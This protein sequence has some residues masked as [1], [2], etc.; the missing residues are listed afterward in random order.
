MATWLF[1]YSYNRSSARSPENAVL[2]KRCYYYLHYTWQALSNT[3]VGTVP[4]KKDLVIIFFRS[5]VTTLWQLIK[6]NN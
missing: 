6:C 2:R 3:W 4:R 1:L 5:F